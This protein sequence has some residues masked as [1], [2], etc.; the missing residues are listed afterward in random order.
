MKVLVRLRASSIDGRHR[1][2]VAGSRGGKPSANLDSQVVDGMEKRN[3]NRRSPSL[4]CALQRSGITYRGRTDGPAF[5]RTHASLCCMKPM[6]FD[7]CAAALLGCALAF[8]SLFALETAVI[9]T[10]SS[11]LIILLGVAAYLLLGP[12]LGRITSR[13]EER[14]GGCE[15]HPT[16][17]GSGFWLGV[18]ISSGIALLITLFLVTPTWQALGLTTAVHHPPVAPLYWT[19]SPDR[20]RIGII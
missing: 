8:W 15:A 14:N 6:F 9:L 19:L 12:A 11:I 17:G 2:E 20:Q 13:N 1:G 16:R 10:A 4:A 5:W 18:A 3:R 7:G